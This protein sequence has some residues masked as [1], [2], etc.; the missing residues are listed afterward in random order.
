MQINENVLLEKKLQDVDELKENPMNKSNT[1]N[2]LG[3]TLKKEIKVRVQL[4]K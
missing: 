4:E 1:M 2:K 3:T